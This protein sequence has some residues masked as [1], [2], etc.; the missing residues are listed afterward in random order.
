MSQWLNKFTSYNIQI[1]YY[2]VL[3]NHPETRPLNSQRGDFQ[4]ENM[5]RIVTWFIKERL[6]NNLDIIIHEP[7]SIIYFDVLG[8]K[9]VA[10]HGQDEKN[11]EKSIQDYSTM[12]GKEI[13]IL[14]TGHLHH[15]SNKTIGMSGTRNIEVI[16]S[17]AI[18]GI[19]EYSVKLKKLSN[20][21]T[22]LTIFE[23]NYGKSN[24]YDIRFN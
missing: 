5:E 11:L 12:Y 3:G 23:K 16:Q 18:C 6:K 13:H 9:I 14:K 8:T 4:Q 20:A 22:L 15:H 17:P 1:E 19:D 10:T 21:G 7:K 2:S 24:T